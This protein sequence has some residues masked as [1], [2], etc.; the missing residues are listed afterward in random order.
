VEMKWKETLR[1]LSPEMVRSGERKVKPSW[2]VSMK[3]NSPAEQTHSEGG[4]LWTQRKMPPRPP[5]P[6]EP[7]PSPKPANPSPPPEPVLPW[8]DRYQFE[9]LGPTLGRSNIIKSVIKQIQDENISVHGHYPR[10][11]SINNDTV[12]PSNMLNK[13]FAQKKKKRFLI[14]LLLWT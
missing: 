14:R 8:R 12:N 10:D 4:S 1:P 11:V 3:Q 6:V 7:T 2:N 9:P 5:R 13:T